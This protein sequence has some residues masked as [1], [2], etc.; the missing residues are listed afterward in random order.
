M[1]E[2]TESVYPQAGRAV[3]KCGSSI[4]TDKHGRIDE[5]RIRRLAAQMVELRNRG[6]DVV[7]VSSGAIAA[8]VEGLGLES[9]PTD[10]PSLQACACVGQAALIDTYA[11]IFAEYGVVVGQI[12]LTRNDT[13]N[14]TSY[15]HAKNTM[16][17]LLELG[18]LPIVNENDTVSV[19][20]IKIGDNDTLAALTA[21][22][23]G[24][25]LVVLLSD[26]DGLYTADPHKDPDA[27]LLSR[28]DRVTDEIVA[29]AGGAGSSVGTGGMYTKVRAARYMM[30]TGVPLVV[31]LGSQENVL[32]DAALGRDV[33]TRFVPSGEP[34]LAMH[35]RKLWIALANKDSGK[36]VVDAGAIRALREKGS[37]LLPVG[38]KAVEGSFD[39]GQGV[40]V[41][42]E[43][44]AIV[45]RGLAGYS[46]DEA[47]MTRGMTLEMVGRIYPDLLGCPLI[48]RDELVVF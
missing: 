20:E 45:G 21:S 38:V 34:T 41:V 30:L 39:R 9:R 13:A 27:R 29:S 1:N 12:L 43:D 3:V 44:G 28:V 6:I 10:I 4:L 2:A 7:F 8:G 32:V 11:R 16:E 23:V 19:D 25:D 5:S 35:A 31:C 42:D 37:S 40:Q 48:H 14:R 36:I 22:L 17:R 26:I 33:G 47:R 46:A 18:V 24:A 15:L